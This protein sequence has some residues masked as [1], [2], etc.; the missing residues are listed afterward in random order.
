MV[1]QSN[2]EDELF[3]Q[4]EIK[5]AV[6][7]LRKNFPQISEIYVN[8]VFEFCQNKYPE[9]FNYI[10]AIRPSKFSLYSK[11]YLTQKA[12]MKKI[13]RRSLFSLIIRYI[14]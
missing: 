14:H 6:D 13:L 4:T 12:A 7:M 9:A 10:Y 1:E 11:V 5:D 2:K 8:N 3:V